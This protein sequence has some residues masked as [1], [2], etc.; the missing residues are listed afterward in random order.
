M[1]KKQ[2]PRKQKLTQSSFSM[3][4]KPENKKTRLKC[5]CVWLEM[6]MTRHNHTHAPPNNL[7]VLG[8]KNPK[9]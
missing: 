8:Y 6:T 4:K 3:Y 9:Q 1:K 2:T 7:L 5:V